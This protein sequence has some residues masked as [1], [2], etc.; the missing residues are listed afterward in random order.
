M[1]ELGKL[2][3]RELEAYAAKL[4][5]AAGA[6][7]ELDL[8]GPAIY[9]HGPAS[10]RSVVLCLACRYVHLILGLPTRPQTWACP[11]CHRPAPLMPP[12]SVLAAAN[13]GA[14]RLAAAI[15]RVN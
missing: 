3:R 12:V 6:V 5:P 8:I 4:E 7:R 11:R 14:D 15:A 9:E 1:G 10:N 2:D 13:A